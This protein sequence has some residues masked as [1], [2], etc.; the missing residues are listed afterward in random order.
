L[1]LLRPVTSMVLTGLPVVSRESCHA[2]AVGWQ[3]PRG[4]HPFGEVV[5]HTINRTKSHRQHG[6]Q[7][8]QLSRQ[9]IAARPPCPIDIPSSGCLGLQAQRGVCSGGVCFQ[10]APV[11]PRSSVMRRSCPRPRTG[12]IIRIGDDTISN[13]RIRRTAD[14]PDPTRTSSGKNTVARP[15]KHTGGGA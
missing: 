1:L 7:V 10:P 11:L 14:G 3:F 12:Q 4:R 13:G 2:S 15:A 5:Y 9:V 8:R 6:Q